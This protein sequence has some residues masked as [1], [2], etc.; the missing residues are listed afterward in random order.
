MDLLNQI[1]KQ[2]KMSEIMLPFV[3]FCIF[4]ITFPANIVALELN[5]NLGWYG[6]DLKGRPCAGKG[7]GVGPFDYNNASHRSNTNYSQI[8]ASHFPP[9]VEQLK[10]GNRGSL[11]GDLDYTLRGIPNNP[12]ALYALSRYQLKRKPANEETPVECYFQRA[13]IFKPDDINVYILYANYLKKMGHSDLAIKQYKSALS[14]K[15]DHGGLHN[16]IGLLYLETKNYEQALQHAHEAYKNGYKR[17]TL[18]NK[19]KAAKKW[20]EA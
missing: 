4:L 9:K 14:Y 5:K 18:K 2:P 10:S 15:P 13:I 3:V 7:Q 1:L 11:Y 20:S 8:L 19:L 16:G 6:S 17:K 12:R